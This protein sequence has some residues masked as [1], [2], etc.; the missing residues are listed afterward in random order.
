MSDAHAITGAVDDD[1]LANYLHSHLI[2]A[3]SGKHL[4]DEATS[5]VAL[6]L[7]SRRRDEESVLGARG[8]LLQTPLFLS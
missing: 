3:S 1:M 2:A 5:N 6:V 7:A 8:L 4:F